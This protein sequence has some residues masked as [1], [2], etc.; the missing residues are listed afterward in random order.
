LSLREQV[1]PIIKL[2]AI[3]NSHFAKLRDFIA[4]HLPSGFPVKIGTIINE[5]VCCNSCGA[6]IDIM[7]VFDHYF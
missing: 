2:L 1:L 3:S 5:I 4:L 6:V 7:S